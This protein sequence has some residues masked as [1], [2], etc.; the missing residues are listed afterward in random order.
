MYKYNLFYKWLS[1][2]YKILSL[3]SF[4][5]TKGTNKII[6]CN[7]SIL[8][9]YLSSGWQ[10]GWMMPFISRYRLSNSISFG[11][12]CE[13]ST[14]ILTPFISLG[15]KQILV[16]TLGEGL[17]FIGLGNVF[18]PLNYNY[19]SRPKAYIEIFKIGYIIPMHP[20]LAVSTITAT[21]STSA[22]HRV[23]L[24]IVHWHFYRCMEVLDN[25]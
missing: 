5:Y 1:R 15:W 21:T 23:H 20:M 18:Q 10:H 14:G 4:S 8:S 16:D 11:F 12:G 3:F 9:T 2:K 24:K 13:E 25:K 7:E 17:K 6:R 22:K 19:Y